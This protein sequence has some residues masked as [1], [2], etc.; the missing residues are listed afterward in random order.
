VA[1]LITGGAGYIGSHLAHSQDFHD[2]EIVVL[3]DLST[4]REKR[5]PANVFFVN[6]S[7][8]DSKLVRYVI[9]NYN[10]KSVFHLAARRQARESAMIPVEY[11]SN[12][13]GS[14]LGLVSA[15]AGSSVE[16]I[17]FAS[18]CSVYGNASLVNSSTVVS[19]VSPYGRTKVSSE[20]ILID[21]CQR[22]GIGLGIMRFFNV[23]GADFG[24]DS[25]D[26]T[27]GALIPG[28]VEAIIAQKQ[29][30]VFGT[31]FLTK[32]GSALRDYLDVRDLVKAH[33]CVF[34]YVSHEREILTVNVCSGVST[35]V[36]EVASIASN[37]LGKEVK[38]SLLPSQAGDPGEITSQRDSRLSELGWTPT[39]SIVDSI[40]SSVDAYLHFLSDS[41][42]HV[43]SQRSQ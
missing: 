10:I 15:I 2:L 40:E 13:V 32:D 5:V 31:E 28:L 7:A 4:G 8:T 14:T 23:I 1:L 27:K 39:Y 42:N 25:A 34:D 16:S 3:D 22:L 11:W 30:Q 6:G 29:F 12:N 36:L 24:F 9:D 33:R 20:N 41:Q 38:L 19:P 37:H 21:A 26:T 18:S 43:H 17:L 35:S